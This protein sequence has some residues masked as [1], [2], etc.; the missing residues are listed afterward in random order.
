MVAGAGSGLGLANSPGKQE[1]RDAPGVVH[2]RSVMPRDAHHELV[3]A[4]AVDV[5]DEGQREPEQIHVL[6]APDREAVTETRL[7][8]SRP[9]E[10]GRHL[11]KVALAGGRP[12]VATHDDVL[13]PVVVEVPDSDGL[14]HVVEVLVASL[15]EQGLVGLAAVVQ[16][17][18]RKGRCERYG[19]RHSGCQNQASRDLRRAHRE[20]PP[21]NLVIE[22][23]EDRI[24]LPP[25]ARAA[26]QSDGPPRGASAPGTPK[27]EM[28]PRTEAKSD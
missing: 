20:P 3:A 19:D 23:P 1:D 8:Q 10:D 15:D 2:A 4:V 22:P 12:V 9:Q 6:D 5:P 18:R 25:S 7:A 21:G 24:S 14:A 27:A 28:L 16:D 11:L 17:L 13:D 26:Y